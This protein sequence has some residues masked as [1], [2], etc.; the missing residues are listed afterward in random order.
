V[1]ES[2]CSA[3]YRQREPFRLWF[4]DKRR[5]NGFGLLEVREAGAFATRFLN[6]AGAKD[7]M[8]SAPVAL[9]SR[10][11]EGQDHIAA[12]RLAGRRRRSPVKSEMEN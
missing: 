2:A 10:T 4:G 9:D 3:L 11:Q 7:N 6:R 8:D 5:A 12:M 1:P